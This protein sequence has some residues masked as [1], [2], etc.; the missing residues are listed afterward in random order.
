V[1]RHTGPEAGLGPAVE[2][3]YRDWLPASGAVLRDAPLFFQ[4][5]KLFPFVPMHEAVTDI[6]MPIK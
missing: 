1:L 6:F 4:R 5:V 3:L 2:W